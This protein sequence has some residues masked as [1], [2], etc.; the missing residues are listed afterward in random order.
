MIGVQ[1][2]YHLPIAPYSSSQLPQS[3]F[4]EKKA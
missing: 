1:G 2:G 4:E 3:A